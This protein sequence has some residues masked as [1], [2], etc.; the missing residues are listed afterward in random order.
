M[1]KTEYRIAL[2]VSQFNSEVTNGLRSGALAYLSENDFSI[3]PEDI[4]SAPGAFEMPL[5][6]KRLAHAGF[7]GVICLGCVIKGET[8][9]FEY[10]SEAV[11][12]GLMQVGL[13]TGK[14]ITFGILTTF[15][16]AQAVERSQDNEHNKGREAA[17]ACMD[18]LRTIEALPKNLRGLA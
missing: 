15:T 13:E 12:H 9:H 14:P 8:A 16:G 18:A 5:I 10:I 17:A 1:P 4:Y 11:V 7:D 6:A 3:A 2:I